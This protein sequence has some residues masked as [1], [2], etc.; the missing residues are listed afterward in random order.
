SRVALCVDRLFARRA[1]QPATLPSRW[2]ARDGARL[3]FL[4]VTGILAFEASERLAFV[5]HVD[6]KYL[7]DVSLAAVEAE[8]GTRVLRTHRNWLVMLD[9]VRELGRASGELAV[10]VGPDLAVPVSRDRAA[11]VRSALTRGVLGSR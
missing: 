9:H 2:M 7:I 4:P 6:G 10:I 11:D 3:V 8:L 1:P 5:H